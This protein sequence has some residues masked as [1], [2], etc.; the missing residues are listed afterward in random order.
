M[1]INNKLDK[2][3]WDLDKTTQE[4]ERIKAAIERLEVERSLPFPREEE[5]NKKTARLK[6]LKAQLDHTENETVEAEHF[7][8]LNGIE[9]TV[10]GEI[11]GTNLEE[12]DYF[13]S[14]FLENFDLTELSDEELAALTFNVVFQYQDSLMALEKGV[15]SLAERDE[16]VL[17]FHEEEEA[18]AQLCDAWTARGIAFPD[19]LQ[20]LN[21]DKLSLIQMQLYAHLQDQTDLPRELMQELPSEK[22]L[23]LG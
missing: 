8:A 19:H 16:L 6:E 15:L 22:Q 5:F 2:L 10:T 11:Q 12:L 20:S 14:S 9:Q 7:L 17:D 18:Y 1:K 23:S 4:I 21:Q 3:F 13:D